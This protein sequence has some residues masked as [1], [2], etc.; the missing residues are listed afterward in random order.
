LQGRDQLQGAQ[1]GFRVRFP[2]IDIRLKA[3]NSDARI[4]QEVVDH[5]AQ[6]I[7]EKVG[8]NVFGEGEDTLEEVVGRLLKEQNLK[9]AVAES[10]TGGFLANLITNV[11]GASDYFLEGIVS[12]SNEAKMKSL[13]V[14]KNTLDSF[15]AVSSETALEMARGVRKISGADIGV[16]VTGIA[17]PTGGSVEKPVGTVHIAVVHPSGE[18]EKV[19]YFPFGRERFKQITAATALD[20]VRRLILEKNHF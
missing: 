14:Q 5:A 2:T 8:D 12:Y 10:C 11:P 7:L 3:K 4:A 20:R 9:I 19:F 1:I 13:G 6:F 18:W 17:G 15:G 16:S